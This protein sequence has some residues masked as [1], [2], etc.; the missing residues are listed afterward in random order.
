MLFWTT[1]HDHYETVLKLGP[2]SGFTARIANSTCGQWS[3]L[4][5]Q[6]S[7]AM[8]V[9]RARFTGDRLAMQFADDAFCGMKWY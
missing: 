9:M 8:P 7:D 2:F 5:L 1:H 6:C 3:V 4:T